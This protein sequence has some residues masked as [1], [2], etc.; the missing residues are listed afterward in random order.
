MGRQGRA[1]SLC[2]LRQQVQPLLATLHRLRDLRAA[3]RGTTPSDVQPCPRPTGRACAARPSSHWASDSC[4]LSS[5]WWV[6]RKGK[7]GAMLLP[8]LL[9]R[10]R[11]GQALSIALAAQV[12]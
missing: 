1:G 3:L 8:C 11:R 6:A 10:D 7:R 4:T 12:L 9:V 5:R 2:L